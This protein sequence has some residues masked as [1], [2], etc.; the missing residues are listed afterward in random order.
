MSDMCAI[1]SETKQW[2]QDLR[3]EVAKPGSQKKDIRGE[4]A[5]PGSIVVR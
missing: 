2:N 4:V 3:G 5:K 1:T